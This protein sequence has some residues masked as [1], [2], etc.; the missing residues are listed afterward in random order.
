MIYD[1]GLLIAIIGVLT[2]AAHSFTKVYQDIDKLRRRLRDDI[3]E[4]RLDH[5]ESRRQES[6]ELQHKLDLLMDHL[7]LEVVNDGNVIKEKK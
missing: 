3:H 2:Y 5:M 7:N 6:L 1:I 4:T